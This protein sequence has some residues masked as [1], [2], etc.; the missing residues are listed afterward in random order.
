MLLDRLGHFEFY[1]AFMYFIQSEKWFFLGKN[2][3]ETLYGN[4][5]PLLNLSNL[6]EVSLTY[7]E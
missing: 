7:Y 4:P 6:T 2:S 5:T 1:C 3:L